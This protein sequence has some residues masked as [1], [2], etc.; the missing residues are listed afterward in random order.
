MPTDT[1]KTNGYFLTTRSVQISRMSRL[2]K[3]SVVIALVLSVCLSLCENRAFAQE[4]GA[5]VTPEMLERLAQLENQTAALRQQLAQLQGASAETPAKT[6]TPAESTSAVSVSK[7]DIETIIEQKIQESAWKKGDGWFR[8]YGMFWASLLGADHR[9]MPNDAVQRV[10]PGEA[11]D[12]S[13]CTVTARR[14]RFGAEVFTPALTLPGVCCPLQMSGRVE[15]DFMGEL[16]TA[17]NKPAVLLRHAYWKAENAQCGF[18]VGQTDDVVSPLTPGALNY[19]NMWF[20]GNIG[21]RNPQVRFS[22]YFYPGQR[23][24]MEAVAALCQISGSDFSAYDQTSGYPT[25]QARLGWTVWRCDPSK[26][27]IQFGISGHIGEQKYAF[28]GDAYAIT[29]WSAN[30]DVKIP[31][32]QRFGIQAEF[33][34]GQGLAG[35]GGGIDQSFDYAIGGFGSRK[36]IHSTG[37]WAECWF[38]ATCKT[39]FTVGAGIDD[40]LDS[41]MEAAAIRQN[42]A[43]YANVVYRFTSYLQTGFEYS[44]WKTL[45]A[46][47][48]PGGARASA[49]VVEWMWQFT[50]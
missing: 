36:S 4:K 2:S 11:Y 30:A 16:G 15:I 34:H 37:G 7:K 8:P 24:R 17:E 21:Y 33:F 46:E 18:L 39:R 12:E 43:I 42:T 47:G 23:T 29:T 49:S 5:A 19:Y 6:E 31:L 10:L 13:V 38:D 22:R 26:A 32:T 45:Y 14:S 28:G 50:F 25:V 3:Y 20:A 1:E 9:F 27:P 44:Y 40:P 48:N 41:D 35:F